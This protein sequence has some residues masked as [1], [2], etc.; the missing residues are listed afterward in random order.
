MLGRITYR[1]VWGW[2]HMKTH[3]RTAGSR[4]VTIC[5]EEGRT[6]RLQ[7]QKRRGRVVAPLLVLFHPLI[8]QVVCL[9]GRGLPGIVILV[10]V[11][12][13]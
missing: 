5:Q 12:T 9:S 7:L 10:R 11:C 1:R 4:A 3:E 8:R 2:G 13:F 6:R